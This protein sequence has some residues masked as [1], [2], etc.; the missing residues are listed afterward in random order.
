MNISKTQ[1]L[2]YN[3]SPPGEIKSKY[4]LAWQPEY[5][6][7]LGVVILKNLTELLQHNYSPIQ[8][9]IKRCAFDTQFVPNK[10]DTRFKEWT[11]KGFKALCKIVKVNTL[12]FERIKEKYALEAQD[13][14]CDLQRRHFVSGKIKKKIKITQT[15]VKS[16]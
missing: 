6:K 4:H 8:V 15:A 14:Y 10:L 1:L 11:N 3:Y 5:L 9:K 7:Y 16:V 2:Q 13:F 12:S